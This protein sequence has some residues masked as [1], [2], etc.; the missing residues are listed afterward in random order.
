M[1]NLEHKDSRVPEEDAIAGQRGP[2]PAEVLVFLPC[3][4]KCKK[5]GQQKCGKRCVLPDR[6]GNERNS[7]EP[8]LP[9]DKRGQTS[10]VDDEQRVYVRRTPTNSRSLIPDKIKQNQFCDVQICSN[11]INVA[12]RIDWVILWDW[13]EC[14]GEDEGP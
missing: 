3:T 1:P 7:R 4:H 14:S 9:D 8:S 13:A 6:R 5:D 2:L 10:Y 11:P 12:S